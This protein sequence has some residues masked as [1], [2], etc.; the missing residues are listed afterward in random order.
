MEVNEAQK[1]VMEVVF[2]VTN[3]YIREKETSLSLLSS[4]IGISPCELVY[5]F[6]ELQN[7]FNVKFKE[8]DILEGK[9]QTVD[10]I[11]DLIIKENCLG[12]C[13]AKL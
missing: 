1:M 6:F 9:I 4:T 13:N 2:H 5:I 10:S 3:K 7:K 8:K 11:V 12:N